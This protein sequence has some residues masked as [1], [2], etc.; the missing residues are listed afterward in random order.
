[1]KKDV[2]PKYFPNAE[3]ICAC[4]NKFQTGSTMPKIK[5]EVCFL[6]HP[7]YTGA[8]KYIDKAGRVDKFQEKMA[9][10]EKM[11]KAKFHHLHERSRKKKEAEELLK[12]RKK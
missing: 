11:Q 4:G 12:T 2:H 10:F 7:F 8:H 3:V 6:C 1:M 5:I 9:K